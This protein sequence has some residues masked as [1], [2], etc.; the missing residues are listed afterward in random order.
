MSRKAGG[1]TN[2][3]DL[4]TCAKRSEAKKARFLCK[5]VWR[6]RIVLEK[7]RRM[8]RDLCEQLGVS[9]VEEWF[10]CAGA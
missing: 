2:Q 8:S 7:R 3:S 10:G 1:L 4:E 5:R 6:I 9:G